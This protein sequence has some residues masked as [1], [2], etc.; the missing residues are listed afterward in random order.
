MKL[1]EIT[2]EAVLPIDA[3]GPGYFRVNEMRHDG[4]MAILGGEVIP[5]KG[6]DDLEPL[7]AASC[8]FDVL[9]VGMGPEIRPLPRAMRGTLEAAGVAV[10]IMATPAACRTY[11]ILLS[12]GRR[13]AVALLPV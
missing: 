2:F 6:L 9:F 10:E 12:E 7:I 3:Y 5:W 8:D 4:A 11:N 1:T 13:V